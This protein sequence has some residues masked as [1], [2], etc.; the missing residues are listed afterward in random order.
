MK[1]FLDQ[2]H[3]FVCRWSFLSTLF[4]M[5][6]FVHLHDFWILIL[7]LFNLCKMDGHCYDIIS[8]YVNGFRGKFDVMPLF[9]LY[10]NQLLSVWVTFLICLCLLL[11]VNELLLCFIQGLLW[12]ARSS[13]Q[14]GYYIFF[15][16]SFEARQ[17]ELIRK[18]VE[19]QCVQKLITLQNGWLHSKYWLIYILEQNF[20]NYWWCMVK[21]MK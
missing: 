11:N 15:L 1:L 16:L 9:Y 13:N 18:T 17:I 21:G 5:A 20:C 19:E 7:M 8:F 6:N 4:A 12:K 3:T 10:L 14:I 2:M